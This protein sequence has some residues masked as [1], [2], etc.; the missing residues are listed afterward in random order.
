MSKNKSTPNLDTCLKA[1][2]PWDRA[3]ADAENAV[4]LDRSKIAQMKRA[5]RAFR[6]M[7][8]AG[9]PW[10]GTAKSPDQS[11]SQASGD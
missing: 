1:V 8:D 7:R 10:P 6:A 2:N 4:A 9:E 3:I 11:G 5:I